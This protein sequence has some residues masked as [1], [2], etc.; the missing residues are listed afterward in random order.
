MFLMYVISVKTK[1]KTSNHSSLKFSKSA[2]DFTVAIKM[3]LY[4]KWT[5]LRR[6]Q[7]TFIITLINR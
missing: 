7:E 6:P 1:A 3:Q 4:Q 5:S 2:E